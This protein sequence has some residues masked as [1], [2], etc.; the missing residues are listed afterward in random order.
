MKV[1]H[2]QGT[3]GGVEACVELAPDY[4]EVDADGLI[5]LAQSVIRPADLDRITEAVSE[6]PTGALRL[7]KEQD[8][9]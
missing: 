2:T 1:V 4:F 3:C 5:H 7:V 8:H 9:A 6:C